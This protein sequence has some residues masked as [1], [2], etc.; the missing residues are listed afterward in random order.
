MGGLAVFGTLSALGALWQLWAWAADSGMA[1]Y[2]RFST[3][4]PA[5]LRVSWACSR[6]LAVASKFDVQKTC[7][8][9]HSEQHHSLVKSRQACPHLTRSEFPLLGNSLAHEIGVF[10]FLDASGRHVLPSD[11]P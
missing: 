8:S 7:L 6:Q 4:L 1:W 11:A 3:C 2:F 5:W 9:G 10:A